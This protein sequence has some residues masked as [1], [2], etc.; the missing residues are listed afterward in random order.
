VKV[1]NLCDVCILCCILHLSDRNKHNYPYMS[2]SFRVFCVFCFDRLK[3]LPDQAIVIVA[4]III[5]PRRSAYR[6]SFLLQL[7][8]AMI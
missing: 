6:V 3:D 2:Y 7:T 8:I 1:V 4:V 5:G